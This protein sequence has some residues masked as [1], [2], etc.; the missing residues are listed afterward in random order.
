MAIGAATFSDFGAAVSDL[1]SYEATGYK[2]Q[3]LQFEQQN[4]EAAA[5][6]ALTN[7]QYTET[8]T[9]IKEQQLQRETY[10]GIGRTEAAV[11]NAGFAASGSALDILKESAQQG[12]TA[13]AAVG[14]QG[15]I[16]E[17]GYQEQHDAYMNMSQ[18]AQS[19]Q[20]A[21]KTAGQGDLFSAGLKLAA[22]LATFLL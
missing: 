22:G 3:A 11:A 21:E 17:A 15:L 5:A 7:K 4:Y 8:S 6:L 10:M 14:Q 20:Q 1:F 9:A 13:K 19:A 2:V 16:T 12:A 18:A